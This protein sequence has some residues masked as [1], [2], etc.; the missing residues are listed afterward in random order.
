VWLDE[1]RTVES[2]MLSVNCSSFRCL[3]L[4]LAAFCENTPNYISLEFLVVN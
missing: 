1:R 3:K 2:I 4:D